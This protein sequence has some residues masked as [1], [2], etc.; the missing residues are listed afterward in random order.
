ME[1]KGISRYQDKLK[2]YTRIAMDYMNKL[3]NIYKELEK[4]L[5]EQ[6]DENKEQNE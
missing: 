5:V 3:E 6:I 2:N 4:D 1:N